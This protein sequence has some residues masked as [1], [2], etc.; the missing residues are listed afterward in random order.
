MKAVGWSREQPGISTIDQDGYL[1]DR[2]HFTTKIYLQNISG[3]WLDLP[4]A[5]V[6]L[7]RSLGANARI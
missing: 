2:S 5:V 1:G 4:D 6:K 3:H 7:H